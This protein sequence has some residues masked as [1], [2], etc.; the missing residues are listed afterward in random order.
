M[1]TLICETTILHTLVMPV[2]YISKYRVLEPIRHLLIFEVIASTL[3]PLSCDVTKKH[4]SI[5]ST[6]DYIH[7]LIQSELEE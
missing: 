4:Y 1:S 6:S 2:E 3:F 7:I 5:I